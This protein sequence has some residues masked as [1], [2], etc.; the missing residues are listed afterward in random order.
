M[1]AG[2]ITSAL[3]LHVHIGSKNSR[4][5]WHTRNEAVDRS[6]KGDLPTFLYLQVVMTSCSLQAVAGN[7][8][9]AHS[10]HVHIGSKNSKG[11]WHTRNEAVD[12]SGKGNLRT[13]LHLQVVM[14]SCS[15]QADA[16]NITSAL[17]LHVH[18]GSKN[19]RGVWHTRNE[20]VDRS[21][22][23]DLPTFLYLQVVTS[24]SLQAVAGNITSA[25]SLHVHIGS[26][27]RRAS[28]THATKL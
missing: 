9:S 15:L 27:N 22:K 10:L 25:H 23:G 11:V 5:V 26:K 13:F 8:T 1:V 21:G 16:G 20:A 28:G 14:T 24:C 6:G 19:I 4:G 18:I 2:S 17:S 12:R 7:I 3:S